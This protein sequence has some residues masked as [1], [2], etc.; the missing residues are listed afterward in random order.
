MT[1][2]ANAFN[3]RAAAALQEPAMLAAVR[4]TAARKQQGRLEA[5]AQLR[6]LPALRDLAADLKR[7]TLDHL[8]R[9]LAQFIERA[10]ALG[11]RVHTA[12]TCR[13]AVD[14]ITRIA[15]DAG[16]ETYVQAKSMTAE[17][18]GILRALQ[19]L[20][21]EAYETDL[22]EYVVQLDGDRP[23]HIVTPIIHKNRRAIAQTLARALDCPYTEDPGRMVAA[24]RRHFRDVFRRADLGLSGVNF[25]VAE[26]GTMCICTNEG[27]GRYAVSRPRIH[28]ALMGLEKLIPRLADLSVF[29]KL[30]ASSSTGQQ[31][32]VY[33]TLLTGPRR[34]DDPDGPEQLHVVILDAGRSQVLGGPFREALACLRCGACLNVC[35][36]FRN[37]G[38]HAYASTYPGPIGKVISPLLGVGE[39]CHELPHASSLC[40]ACLEACPVKIDIPQLLLEHRAGQVEGGRLD[41]VKTLAYRLA[42][43]AMRR[44]WTFR[45]GQRFMR[46]FLSALS[47][48]GWVR[49]VPGPAGGW[50]EARDIP[51]N[52][53]QTFHDYWAE[54]HAH[55]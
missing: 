15:R 44:R 11:A 9:Y 47:R 17:E 8:D 35:P 13:D 28:V 34:P 39:D 48:D 49:R 7:H 20:G 42:F 33:S 24:V 2:P 31:I 3:Q 36:V 27:N 22:G 41:R 6:D 32:T 23:S 14:I 10:E 19:K 51:V 16:A 21:L 12:A 40:G 1:P 29:L 50:T 43:F 52:P 53:A 25:A 55:E 38:G 46:L 4:D 45:L 37:V 30:L 26:T 54:E 18:I 5:W